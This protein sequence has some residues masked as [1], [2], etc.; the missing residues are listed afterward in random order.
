[1]KIKG[2][3]LG[4]LGLVVIWGVFWGLKT[5]AQTRKATAQ[6]IIDRTAAQ[7]LASLPPQDRPGYLA[8]L[9]STVNRLS[10]E[11]RRQLALAR[12]L[13][14]TFE[15]MSDV[16]RRAF[17][18]ATLPQGFNQILEVFNKMEP[19]ERK[20]AVERALDDL[21]KADDM[22]RGADWSR[23]QARIEDGTLQQVVE[24]GFQSYLKTA[25]AE[26]KLDLAP[27]IEQIQQN[28]RSYRHP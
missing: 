13:D 2:W 23:T 8:D 19:T 6:A 26:T 25:S 24:Q 14:G 27:V 11:E 1:M 28:L 3:I 21:R 22:A 7:P 12:G 9:A 10:F 5:T 4:V 18:D 17:L 15:A 16:E 20:A